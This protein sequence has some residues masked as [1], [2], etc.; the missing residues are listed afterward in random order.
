MSFLDSHIEQIA[1]GDHGAF[2]KLHALL[3]QRLFYYAYKIIKNVEESEDL[4]QD[5][6]VHY[7]ENRKNFQELVPVKVYLYST[8]DYKIR[9]H[10]RKKYRQHKL[11]HEIHPAESYEQEHL[12]LSAELASQVQQAIRKLSP[13]TSQILE[14]SLL[15]MS[16]EEIAAEMNISVN[17]VK[18]LKKG[19]YKALRESL[20]HLKSLLPILFVP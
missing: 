9:N 5:T 4:V 18:T 1:S 16:Q 7:W 2:E 19:G 3:Y 6:F 20:A 11:I 10:T 13:Q 15:E 12:I 17:T 14:L 8:L